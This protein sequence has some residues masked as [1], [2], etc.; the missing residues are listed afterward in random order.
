MFKRTKYYA[1]GGPA[2][3]TKYMAK[4]GKASKYMAKGGKASKYCKDPNYAKGSKKRKK[5]AAGGFVG[6]RGQG[7]VMRERLR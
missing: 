6:I 7:A 5:K 2:K 3:K 4:G 1:T